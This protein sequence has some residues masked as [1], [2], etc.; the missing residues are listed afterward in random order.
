MGNWRQSSRYIHSTN[1]T[2]NSYPKRV[3]GMGMRLAAIT[4][5]NDDVVEGR[6]RVS[7]KQQAANQELGS[8][9]HQASSDNQASNALL[10]VALLPPEAHL[11]SH[12]WDEFPI[13]N[14]QNTVRGLEDHPYQSFLT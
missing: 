6:C 10:P 9:P 7:P 4:R 13:I 8:L 3:K 5:E 12:S 1:E 14:T 2:S 11:Y